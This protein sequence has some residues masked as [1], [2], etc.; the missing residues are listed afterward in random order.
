MWIVHYLRL[1]CFAT[2]L[3]SA[4]QL[5]NFLNLYYQRLDATLQEVSLQMADFQ[6]IAN[7]HFRGDVWALVRHHEKSDDV[8]VKEQAEHIRQLFL[9]QQQLVSYM[10]SWHNIWYAPYQHLLS[11]PFPDLLARSWQHYDFALVLTPKAVV[12]GVLFATLSVFLLELFLH[13]LLS[14]RP[15]PRYK[16]IPPHHD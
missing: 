12:T 4:I 11:N 8:V 2:V 14:L 9:R 10:Q 15:K 5:P 1:A 13:L 3:L 6:R 16:T 7:D